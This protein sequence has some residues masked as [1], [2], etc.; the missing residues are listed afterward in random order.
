MITVRYDVDQTM[1]N[2]FW[3]ESHGSDFPRSLLVMLGG[4]VHGAGEGSVE[5][6]A[7][8]TYGRIDKVIMLHTLPSM[9]QATLRIF[10]SAATTYRSREM[11]LLDSTIAPLGYQAFPLSRGCHSLSP[12]SGA[13]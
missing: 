2:G 9:E 10:C 7:D 1:V 5:L 11:Y 6:Q 8:E 4:R 3:V 13:L 12:L